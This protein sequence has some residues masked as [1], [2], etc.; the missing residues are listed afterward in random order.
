VHNREP[1]DLD[2]IL[3]L[4]GRQPDWQ[5]IDRLSQ[6]IRASLDNK[7]PAL[8]RKRPRIRQNGPSDFEIMQAW[9]DGRQLRRETF[10]FSLASIIALSIILLATAIVVY[11][12]M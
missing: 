1:T 8:A 12:V 10:Y 5:R 11:F 6:E 3:A 9:R 7:F 4:Q 2:T